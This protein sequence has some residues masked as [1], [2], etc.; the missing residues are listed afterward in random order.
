M[1]RP[2]GDKTRCGG[3]WTEAKFTDFVKNQIRGGTR[4]WAPIHDCFRRANI[5]R[6][7]FKCDCCGETK[8]KTII[9]DK[10]K[11]VKN[12]AIDHIKPV[13]DPAVGFTTWDSFIENSF[14][15]EDNL[16]TLCSDCHR[17]KTNEEIQVAKDRRAKA[18]EQQNLPDVPY[19]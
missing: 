3:R 16:Q 2:S 17:I 5:D 18:K 9:N 15:E 19:L 8:P 1:A 14:C 12:Y 10:R 11:R 7:N 6:H 13:I 4:K